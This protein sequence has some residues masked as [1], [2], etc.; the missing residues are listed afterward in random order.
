MRPSLHFGAPKVP[1]AGRRRLPKPDV[2]AAI[3]RGGAGEVWIDLARL[4]N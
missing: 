4:P 2:E 1:G 3:F